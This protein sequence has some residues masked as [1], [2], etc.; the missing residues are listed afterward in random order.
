MLDRV[1]S[2]SRAR[3]L[4]LVVVAVAIAGAAA[5]SAAGVV[6][7]DVFRPHAP[8][9]AQHLLPGMEQHSDRWSG[10]H[11][12]AAS[13]FLA[14]ASVA[15]PLLLW[16]LHDAKQAV[17]HRAVVITASATALV[18]AVL[19]LATRVL[20]EWDQLALRSVTVGTDVSGYWFAGFGKDVLFILVDDHE[21]TQREYVP[22]LLAHLGAPIVGVVAL[23]IVA[24]AL[25]RNPAQ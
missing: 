22:A 1:K 17:R 13:V 7:A 4:T 21:I 20:V 19:T 25:L 16:L 12:L 2:P 14:G 8:G 24:V 23:V 10:W 11:R 6:L 3:G 15:L 5:T 18:M 9:V